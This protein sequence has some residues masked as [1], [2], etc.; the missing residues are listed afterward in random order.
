LLAAVRRAV[1]PWRSSQGSSSAGNLAAQYE[2]TLIG[3]AAGKNLIF[4]EATARKL[5]VMREEL[6]GEK[7]SPL[8]RLLVERI[9][10]CWLSLYDVEIRFARM[11]DLTIPQ[12]TYWQDRIDRAHRR[13]LTAI[14]A[15]ATVRKMALPALQVNVAKK[16]GELRWCGLRRGT[17][18]SWRVGAWETN[19][20]L[21]VVLVTGQNCPTGGIKLSRVSEPS[22]A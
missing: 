1:R 13:Y 6:A 11:K 17:N 10:L 16:T 20:G 3:S 18:Q 22:H 9:V 7:A 15:P 8:Q 14:K 12:A 21:I 19:C 2:V 5:K 4:K